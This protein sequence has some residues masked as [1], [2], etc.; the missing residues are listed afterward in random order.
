LI[1][2][3]QTGHS[4]GVLYDEYLQKIAEADKLI[5]DFVDCLENRGLMKNTTLIICAD[6]GQADGIGGHGHLDEGERFVPF[7]LNGPTIRHGHRIDEKHSLISMAPTLSYLLGAPYP[8][9]SRGPV[10]TEA[11]KFDHIKDS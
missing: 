9:N 5:E 8:S 2:V 6:H 11:F 1:G 7:F 3:D 4:R 10:L